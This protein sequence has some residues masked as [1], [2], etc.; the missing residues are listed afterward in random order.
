MDLWFKETRLR[1]CF[2]ILYFLAINFFGSV[3]A[4]PSSTDNLSVL[5]ESSSNRCHIKVLHQHWQE[6]NRL[7]KYFILCVSHGLTAGE[8]LENTGYNQSVTD[9]GSQ[10]RQ[11]SCYSTKTHIS[12]VILILKLNLSSLR[13]IY[14]K[15][16]VVLNEDHF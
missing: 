13:N 5:N 16:S 9:C 14:I 10:R 7:T 2:K 3:N 1:V 15:M 4:F 11:C 8:S 6:E 12:S